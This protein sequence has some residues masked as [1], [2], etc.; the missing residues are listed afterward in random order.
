MEHHDTSPEREGSVSK[1]RSK[2]LQAVG[3]S[4]LT[5]AK[6]LEDAIENVIIKAELVQMMGIKDIV[7]LMVMDVL[8]SNKSKSKKTE[9]KN[10]NGGS[11]TVVSDK[12]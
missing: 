11:K 7:F 8:N 2:S 1:E 9:D 5:E 3:L 10:S 12:H 6:M 4:R